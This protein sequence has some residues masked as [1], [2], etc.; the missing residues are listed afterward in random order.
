VREGKVAQAGN[1]G[2][3]S[4]IPPRTGTAGESSSIVPVIAHKY[5]G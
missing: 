4:L 3:E 5:T 1:G 2:D